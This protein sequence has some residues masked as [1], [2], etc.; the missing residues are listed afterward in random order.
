MADN[1]LSNRSENSEVF[2][3]FIM[4]IFDDYDSKSID[5]NQ[6][7]LALRHAFVLLEN[8]DTRG[9]IDWMKQGRKHI[10]NEIVTKWYENK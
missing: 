5:R 2:E 4:A 7:I 10:R 9:A 1:I 6:A 8:G 3:T